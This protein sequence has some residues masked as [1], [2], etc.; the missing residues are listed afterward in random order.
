MLI[1]SWLAYYGFLVFIH[2]STMFNSCATMYTTFSSTMI[3]LNW[4]LCVGLCGIIDFCLYSGFI[5]F[6]NSVTNTLIIERK[7]KGE[8]NDYNNL[9]KPL[10]KYVKLYKKLSG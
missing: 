3:Y 7:K 2:F 5:N 6:S 4:I 9:P 10:E 1:F 8:L